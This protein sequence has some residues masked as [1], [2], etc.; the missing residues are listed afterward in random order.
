[1]LKIISLQLNPLNVGSRVP[2]EEL[3]WCNCRWLLLYP[4]R[5]KVWE[6]T[7]KSEM[8]LVQV[9]S[10]R[11]KVAPSDVSYSVP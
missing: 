10:R 2:L 3:W 6:K 11:S 8:T 7:R 1:M 9:T 4:A 5:T